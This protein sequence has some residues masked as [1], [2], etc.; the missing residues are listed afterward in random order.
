[1]FVEQEV[2]LIERRSRHLLMVLFVHFTKRHG[3]GQDLIQNLD[4]LLSRIVLQPDRQLLESAVTLNLTILDLILRLG[5]RAGSSI[6]G[7]WRFFHWGSDSRPMRGST[8]RFVHQRVDARERSE[9]VAARRAAG[10]WPI[11]IPD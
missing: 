10:L 7:H 8:N 2:Q 11:R 6:L 4:A 9:A 5:F 3:I 1:V